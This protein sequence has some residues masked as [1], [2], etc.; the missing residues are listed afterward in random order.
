MPFLENVLRGRN[1]PRERMLSVAHHY[2]MFGGVSPIN[3]QNRDYRRAQ[4]GTQTA[5]SG[6]SDLLGQ[7]QL[8]SA[9]AGYV[10]ANGARRR[11]AMRS[12]LLLPLTVRS[13]VAGSTGKTLL[14]R[15]PKLD[16][17]RRG[18]TS[19]ARFTI[20]RCS[21]KQT[22]TTFAP[23]CPNLA[24]LAR[25]RSL[26]SRRTVFRKRWLRT[27]ITRYNSAKLDSLIAETLGTD[28][29]RVVYQSRSGSPSQPWLGPDIT[30]CSAGDERG[31]G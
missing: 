14:T 17:A 31:R 29:W 3:Q 30:D 1:V 24:R 2:E 6:P 9:A 27:V 13:R 16:Q 7:S 15:R 25:R 28:R 12:R 22:W 11:F 21:S 19:C 8:A 26:F 23:R 10:A 4:A 18:S 20:I 5:R